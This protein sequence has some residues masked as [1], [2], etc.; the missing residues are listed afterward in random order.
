MSVIFKIQNQ[1]EI[2]EMFRRS[3]AIAQKWFSKGLAGSIQYLQKYNRKGIT[4]YDTGTMSQT[5]QWS[6]VNPKNE[7]KF[8]PTRDYAKFVYYGT[9][10]QRPQKFL[11]VILDRATP[12]IKQL[13]M[14]VAD[15]IGKEITKLA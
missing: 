13:F 10:F 12:E 6:P 9:R 5:F 3:P 8:F 15:N 2:E 1:K 11:D 7:I 14:D 4:P